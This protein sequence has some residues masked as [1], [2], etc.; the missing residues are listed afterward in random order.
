MMRGTH[1]YPAITRPELVDI[2]DKIR[3]EF[4]VDKGIV[5]VKEGLVADITG[6]GPTRFFVTAEGATIATYQPGS[7]CALK[8]VLLAKGAHDT[9]QALFN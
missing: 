9:Q 6:H 7:Y 1:L 4:P 8:F 2:G 3:V 5:M